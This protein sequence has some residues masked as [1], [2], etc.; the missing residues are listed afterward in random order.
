MCRAAGAGADPA[1]KGPAPMRGQYLA[2]GDGKK[3]ERITHYG[4]DGKA[5]GRS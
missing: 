2:S 1:K 4:N 5:R 3:Y